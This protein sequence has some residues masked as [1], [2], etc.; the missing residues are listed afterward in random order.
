[1]SSQFMVDIEGTELS[2]LEHTILKQPNVGA[3]ILFTRNFTNPEQLAQLIFDI[4]EANPE[5]FIAVDHEGG[6]VQRFQR[7]GF[8]ALPAARA[9]GR[10]YDKNHEVGIAYTQEYGEIMAKELLACGVDLSIA[11]VLDVHEKSRVIAGLDRAFHEDAD[12]VIDLAGAF[13]KGMNT[14][15]MPAVGKHFPGHGSVVSDSHIAMPVSQASMAELEANDLKP[16]VELINK[17]LLT[18]LMPAHVTY[19]AIDKK[20]PAGFSTIWL[21][22][23]LRTKLGFKGLVLSDCLSMKGA[24]IGNLTTRAEKALSAGCDMLIV[25]HQPRELLLELIQTLN[26]EQTTESKERIAAFK[27][28]MLRFSKNTEPMYSPQAFYG[29]KMQES[30]TGIPG[31]HDGLNTTVSI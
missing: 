16:F 31:T 3:V 30:A 26:I 23:I 27:N 9:Y 6:N 17:G 2:A 18:A 4:G 25:C 7:Q 24:D 19:E 21:Q 15:G 20:N 29:Q 12:A 22:D 11:P 10:V 14:A 5:L 28:Q 13:I 8:S 1:M